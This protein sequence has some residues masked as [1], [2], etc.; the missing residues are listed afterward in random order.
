MNKI[1]RLATGA[2]LILG[3]TLIVTGCTTP[4]EDKVSTQDA[5]DTYKSFVDEVYNHNIDADTLYALNE[6]VVPLIPAGKQD[7]ALKILKDSEIINTDH[8]MLSASDYTNSE[9]ENASATMEFALNFRVLGIMTLNTVND[10]VSVKINPEAITYVDDVYKIKRS[11]VTF[12][13]SKN[14]TTM[15]ADNLNKEI[16]YKSEKDTTIDVV[17][18]KDGLKVDLFTTDF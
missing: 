1:K 14:E 17:E 3:V 2:A 12:E 4:E 8:V 15:L 13:S 11:G 5:V 16:G 18:T 10:T 7:E 6:E 9:D